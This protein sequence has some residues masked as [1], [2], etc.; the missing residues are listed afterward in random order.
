MKKLI[1]LLALCATSAGAQVSLFAGY[2]D[3][4]DLGFD[5]G[6]VAGVEFGSP[7]FRIGGEYA[8]TPKVYTGTDKGYAYD[9]YA[10]GGFLHR[11]GFGLFGTVRYSGWRA[12]ERDG[13]TSSKDG[14]TWALGPGYHWGDD[15]FI[16]VLV[17]DDVVLGELRYKVVGRLWAGVRVSYLQEYGE[18]Y[19]LRLG[20]RIGGK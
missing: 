19:S 7:R 9:L 20:Y 16:E 8:H 6:P 2:E 1:V 13:S 14:D 11:S 5:A 4:G 15:S 10:T 3:A 12:K 17:G 18:S